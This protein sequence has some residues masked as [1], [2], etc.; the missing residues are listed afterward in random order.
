[1]LVIFNMLATSHGCGKTWN[2]NVKLYKISVCMNNEKYTYMLMKQERKTE[3]KTTF[4][5]E[6]LIQDLEIT[7]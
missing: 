1:M 5:N 2:M 6:N 4:E 7:A 3:N